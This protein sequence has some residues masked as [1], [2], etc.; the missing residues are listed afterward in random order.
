M[1]S[2]ASNKTNIFQFTYS[3]Q[4]KQCNTCGKRMNKGLFKLHK[5]QFHSKVTDDGRSQEVQFEYCTKIPPKPTYRKHFK[6]TICN[7]TGMLEQELKKHVSKQHKDLLKHDNIFELTAIKVPCELCGNH[8]RMEKIENH[9]N[10]VHRQP[11]PD[12]IVTK[13]FKCQIC[14]DHIISERNL[15]QHNLKDC[16]KKFTQ[17]QRSSKKDAIV[18]ISKQAPITSN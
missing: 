16:L 6:C 2:N 14:G 8:F 17:P 1:H 12:V 3:V 18:G 15:E 5:K 7:K 4:R 13:L 11:D 9:M 10:M